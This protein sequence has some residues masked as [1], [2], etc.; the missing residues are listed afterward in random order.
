[1]SK[2]PIARNLDEPTVEELVRQET[3]PREAFLLPQVDAVR[4]KLLSGRDRLRV[5][6]A[7][8][9]VPLAYSDAVRRLFAEFDGDVSAFEA[10][11][12]DYRTPSRRQ[13]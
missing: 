1:M 5:R 2:L 12:I 3:L 6:T 7:A 9:Y 8:S 11:C 13:A 4:W 10:A